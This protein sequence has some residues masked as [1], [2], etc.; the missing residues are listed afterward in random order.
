MINDLH[1]IYYE[2]YPTN[3]SLLKT[4]GCQFIFDNL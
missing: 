4:T 2:L 1:L 3:F